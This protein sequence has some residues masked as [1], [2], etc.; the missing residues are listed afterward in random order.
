MTN[1]R[2]SGMMATPGQFGSDDFSHWLAGWLDRWM[3]GS[4]EGWMVGRLRIAWLCNHPII[5][6]SNHPTIHLLSQQHPDDA[7]APGGHVPQVKHK[8]RQPDQVIG[9]DRPAKSQGELAGRHRPGETDGPQYL[10]QQSDQYQV[11]VSLRV[12]RG[13]PVAGRVD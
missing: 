11:R 6:P 8:G 13:P 2:P 3:A 10:T 9:D 5:Q 7:P 4:L 12:T 1:T